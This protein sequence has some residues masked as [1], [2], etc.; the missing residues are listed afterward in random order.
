MKRT[1]EVKNI[2]GQVVEIMNIEKTQ[3][4]E[5]INEFALEESKQYFILGKRKDNG[6]AIMNW[7]KEIT[8]FEEK[9]DIKKPKIK[10]KDLLQ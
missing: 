9:E 10:L 1:I 6:Y 7:F 2:N 3:D 8:G 4:G 5:M